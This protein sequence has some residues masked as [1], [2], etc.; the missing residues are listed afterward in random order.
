MLDAGTVGPGCVPVE[1]ALSTIGA[2]GVNGSTVGVTFCPSAKAGT[3]IVGEGA[4][5][6]ESDGAAVDGGAGGRT[7]SGPGRRRGRRRFGFLTEDLHHDVGVHRH[8]GAAGDDDEQECEHEGPGGRRF[9]RSARGRRLPGLGFDVLQLEIGFGF[10]GEQERP[11]RSSGSGVSRR[12]HHGISFR[13][14]G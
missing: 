10:P 14:V 9:V 5:V 6:A 4:T 13:K 7:G 3:L 11:V 1:L 2:L 12:S 8:V